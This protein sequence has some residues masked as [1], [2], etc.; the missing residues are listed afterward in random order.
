VA[1]FGFSPTG[2]GEMW[3]VEYFNNMGLEG[4][5]V[6]IENE[7][8]DGIARNYGQNVPI[9]GLPADGWSA[10]WTRLVEFPAGVYTFTLRADDTA[11]VLIDGTE[12]LNQ[13]EW[14]DGTSLVVQAEIPAGRHLI[15][16]EYTE[17]I[18]LANL[19]LTWDPQ[20][21]T[22]LFEDGCNGAT[23]GVNGSAASCPE[24]TP[25]ISMPVV[26]RA[27]PLYFRPE[28]N[29]ESGY[30][31][32]LH[33]GEEYVAVGRS[34]DNIWINLEAHGR[35][36]WSMTEFL[37]LS[38]NINDLPITDGSV[39][40]TTGLPTTGD[41]AAGNVVTIGDG[42]GQTAPVPTG[43]RA[44]AVGNMRIRSGPGDGFER[45]GNVDWGQEVNV[46]GRSADN[47]WLKIESNGVT[48]WSSLGWYEFISGSLEEVPVTN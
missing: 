23:A 32:F 8:A 30:I 6:V 25:G 13:T 28:P 16:V 24:R 2:G 17:L 29:R 44:V 27:G 26:V 33:R 45:I 34:A 11:R 10:R 39:P 46:L 22:T 41:A 19:F 15:V 5:P 40:L 1:A 12:I 37:T 42:A 9:D 47:F 14:L 43:I 21:G 31:E 7:P 3:S 35:V 4:D 18:D 20:I 48:G 38:G 36:A